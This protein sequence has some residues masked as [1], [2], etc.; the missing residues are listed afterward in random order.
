MAFPVSPTNGQQANINGITYTYSA[1]L[2]AWTVSTSVSN[3]FVSINVSANVNS[4]NVLNTGIISSTGNVTGG[5]LLTSGL[6]SATSTITSAA[7]V[8]GGN[9]RTSGLISATGAI[10]GAAITGSSLTVTT[11]NITGGNLILSGAIV[12]SAQLDIQTSAVN[13]NIVFTPN[14]SGNVNM[15]TGLSVTGNIQGG[16]LRTA[17]LI[18]S[19]GTITGSSLLGTV[20]SVTA[21]VTGGNVLTGG[22][23]SAAGN[24]AGNI[25]ISSGGIT[26][27]ATQVASAD[28]NTL[29]DYEEGTWTPVVTSQNGSIT[30]YTATGN[31]TKIGRTV[32]L[33]CNIQITNVGTGSGQLFV[34]GVPFNTLSSNQY[35]GV[36]RETTATGFIYYPMIAG[37]QINIQNDTNGGVAYSTNYRYESTNVYQTT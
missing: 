29:D 27:P 4:G 21:N 8:S 3:T 23:I 19:T 30:S 13:A 31:Y 17:G 5:N 16:N 36:T 22:L 6:I 9:L 34:S 12:D 1:A 25:F 28:A 32:T 7:N 15:T 14:G 24:V 11:G 26:F 2:T 10:T 35:M 33:Y 20:V 18:S 37:S